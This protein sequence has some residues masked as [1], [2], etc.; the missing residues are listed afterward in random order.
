[1]GNGYG[2]QE[3]VP[4]ESDYAIDELDEINDIQG[5]QTQVCWD[6]E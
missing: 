3:P 5:S 2:L 1:L 6:E 4:E